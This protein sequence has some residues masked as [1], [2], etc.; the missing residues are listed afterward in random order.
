MSPAVP[1]ASR[2]AQPVELEYSQINT[3]FGRGKEGMREGLSTELKTIT[4]D[5][6]KVIRRDRCSKPM[7]A[8][9]GLGCLGLEAAVLP[10]ILRR[11][12]TF[13]FGKCIACR[14]E[15]MLHVVKKWPN[16]SN[17]N[18]GRPLSRLLSFQIQPPIRALQS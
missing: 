17:S 1:Q 8:C 7:T 3:Y 11:G 12:N 5:H 6:T 4:P 16:H 14:I 13:S 15:H 9:S 18:N 2:I 10:S